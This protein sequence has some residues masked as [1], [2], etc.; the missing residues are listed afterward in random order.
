MA[1]LGA[2]ALER[3]LTARS[4]VASLLLGQHPP[5]SSSARLVRWCALFGV[6]ENA[7]RVALSRM[8]ERG[9]L[10]VA[11]GGYELAGAV[12]RRQAPQDWVLAPE[13][14]DWDG[15]WRLALVLP[16]R[17]DAGQRVALREATRR[18]RLGLVR[19]GVWTRPANLP[20]ASAPGELWDRVDAQCTWWDARPPEARALARRLFD[21]DGWAR[22]G[23]ELA[24]RVERIA[25]RLDGDPDLLAEG[26]VVGAAALQHLRRDP[27]LP[28]ELLPAG[29][30]G[31]R[32]RAAYQTYRAAYGPAVA[33][34]LR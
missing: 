33:A 13:L 26:F 29:W 23:R 28:T 32:L 5:R 24:G 11:D 10:H 3:P 4:I 34:H 15:G 18:L 25:A 16:D 21:P 22:R 12:R 2:D 31:A 6:S 9:E 7:T 19:E 30:P 17:R 8:V 27:L 20:R 1:I 14:A